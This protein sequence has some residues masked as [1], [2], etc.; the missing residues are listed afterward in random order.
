MFLFT[1]SRTTSEIQPAPAHHGPRPLDRGGPLARGL[2]D[3]ARRLQPPP[4][5]PNRRGG[6]RPLCGMLEARS[7]V[8]RLS[9]RAREF[10]TG[11]HEI[12]ASE[13]RSAVASHPFHNSGASPGRKCLRKE[14][15]PRPAGLARTGSQ[16]VQH[17]SLTGTRP[18]DTPKRTAAEWQAT[19]ARLLP[20][21]YPLPSHIRRNASA[22]AI[23][24][25]RQSLLM[26]P[27]CNML[28]RPVSPHPIPTPRA[29]W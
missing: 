26:G 7:P 21:D 24:L 13:T 14:V 2:P 22:V 4:W 12:A 16:P 28:P 3:L 18:S 8:R 1:A 15:M 27:Q 23:R 9:L 10:P 19:I 29:C 6:E 5:F 11:R 25:A 17:N 20:D